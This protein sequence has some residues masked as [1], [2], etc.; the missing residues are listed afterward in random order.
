MTPEQGDLLTQ[1]QR[2]RDSSWYFLATLATVGH[3]V[4]PQGG[5]R[6]GPQAT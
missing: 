2:V 3:S 6:Q 5:R 4:A 1:A